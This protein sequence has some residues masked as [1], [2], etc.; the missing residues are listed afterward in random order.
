VHISA[1]PPRQQSILQSIFGS[2][3]YPQ[4]DLSTPVGAPSHAS[5]AK[6][7]KTAQITTLE[8][9]VRVVSH[10]TEKASAHF[11]VHFDAG[12]RYEDISNRG[13]SHFLEHH[14]LKSTTNRSAFR[15]TR[16]CEKL[17]LVV[18]PQT[19]REMTSF[20]VDT[21][22]DHA[23]HAMG[24]IA[25]L[26]TN[27][28]FFRHELETS[29]DLYAELYSEPLAESP[30]VTEG[31]LAAAF[32]NNTYGNPFMA[33]KADL[34]SFTT[35]ALFNHTS[36]YF[37]ADRVV[38]SGVGMGHDALVN[39][40]REYLSGLPGSSGVEKLAPVY[41]GGESRL[42]STDTGMVNLVLGFQA[43]NWVENDAVAVLVLQTLMGGG[44]SFSAG[45]PGK[46]MYTRLY[47]NVLQGHAWAF[48]A[49]CDTHLFTDAGLFTLSGATVPQNA[50]S[51]LSVLIKEAHGMTGAYND[52]EVSRAKNM[53]KSQVLLA[54]EH[55]Q[56]QQQDMAQQ[57]LTYGK[58]AAPAEWIAKINAVTAADLQRVAGT[59]L[60]S[61]LS[62]ACSGDSTYVPTYQEIQGQF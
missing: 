47:R 56:I 4:T 41:T 52:T 40:A 36:R 24:T 39:Y 13:I 1:A 14:A 45:G 60:K 5:E 46:G 53:L 55:R 35:E 17:G 48:D 49:K 34:A 25:D 32:R 11:G 7:D 33:T 2:S 27:A 9:G 15:L 10:N 23:P 19:S 31:I 38:V 37:T 44:S 8:N 61:P 58:V 43:P 20:N 29:K 51:M 59:L 6:E 3:K 50:A 57:L 42:A 26:A 62:F 21:L 28:E 22:R 16:E 18:S 12:S 54:L 30:D